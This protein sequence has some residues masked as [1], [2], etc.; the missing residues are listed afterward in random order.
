VNVGSGGVKMKMGTGSE[1]ELGGGP[2]TQVS[3]VRQAGGSFKIGIPPRNENTDMPM[4]DKEV[5]GQVDG[6]KDPNDITGE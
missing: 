5:L 2:V 3:D 1:N 4:V 6:K